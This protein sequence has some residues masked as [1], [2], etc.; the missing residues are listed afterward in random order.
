MT[1]FEHNVVS[2]YMHKQSVTNAQ[3][4]GRMKDK[5]IPIWHQQR[6]KKQSNSRWNTVKHLLFA[7]HYF[8]EAITEDIFTRL[9]FRDLSYLVL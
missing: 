5:A 2:K 4:D 7:W 1:V 3:T 9:Y 8:R 6:R